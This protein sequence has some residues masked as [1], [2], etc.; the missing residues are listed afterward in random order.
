MTSTGPS[1]L[2]I[3]LLVL[4][5]NAIVFLSALGMVLWLRKKTQEAVVQ[6]GE[7]VQQFA[8]QITRLREFLHLYADLSWE[9]FATPVQ[10]LSKEAEQ[11]EAQVRDLQDANQALQ[12]NMEDTGGNQLQNIINAPYHWLMHWRQ[13]RDLR[14]QSA[15]INSR[16]TAAEN[17]TE[18]I[19]GLPWQVAMESRKVANQVEEITQLVETLQQNGVGGKMMQAILSQIP[20]IQQALRGVPPVF[21]SSEQSE[22]LTSADHGETG[23]VYKSIRRVQPNI[24]RWLPQLHGWKELYDNS[25]QE[26]AALQQTITTLRQSF[27]QP[28]AGLL[29]T[30]IKE[31]LDFV[32]ENTT[33]LGERLSQPEAEQLKALLREIIRL[34]RLAEDAGQRFETASKRVTELAQARATLK[35]SLDQLSSQLDALE[36][37]ETHPLVWNES[38]P[39]LLSL[40]QRLQALG[41]AEQQRTPEEIDAAIQEVAQIQGRQKELAEHDPKMAAQYETLVSL[42][43]SPEIQ[44]GIA[45]SRKTGEMIR[46]AEVYDPKSWQKPDA[47]Q[48]LQADLDALSALQE[49][50]VPEDP[51]AVIKESEL[52]ERLKETQQLAE[53]HKQLRPRAEAI[54]TRLNQ[55][56]ALE[57]EAAGKLKEANM[58]LET[59]AI[60]VDSNELLQTAAPEIKNLKNELQSLGNLLND[61]KQGT[62]EKK[63]QRVAS[64]SSTLMQT[65][66]G[67]LARLND[68]ISALGK[69]INE[70]LTEL[71][72]IAILEDPPFQD[73]RNLL[74]REDSRPGISFAGRSLERRSASKNYATAQELSAEIK[75]KNDLWQTFIAALEALDEKSETV[76]VAYREAIAARTSAQEQV[77]KVDEHLPQRRN[78]PPVNQ[79]PLEESQRL[80]AVDA[81]WDVMKQQHVRSDWAILEMGRLTQ[82]YRQVEEYARQL[83]ERVT[84][85]QERITDQEEQVKAVMER[86]QLM[87]QSAP[88]NA[89]MIQAIDQLVKN[90]A[91]QLSYIRTQYLRGTLNYNDVSHSLQLLYDEIYHAQV[92]LDDQHETGLNNNHNRPQP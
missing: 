44:E 21:L 60:L 79:A 82:Q 55:I 37:K 4:L 26:F 11:I 13:A 15:V 63:Q 9:P 48:T 1:A 8:E 83:I 66:S 27:A 32:V 17:E 65:M 36:K 50:L 34:R 40:Y 6:I 12:A 5:A 10:D 7:Q 42:L 19:H 72:A 59:V 86:W 23:Q 89:L 3:V 87:A 69:Q 84:Q 28:P 22:L 77:R 71:K 67:W 78:W 30:P 41:P 76:L 49:R 20:V 46:Q 88:D 29:I 81:K 18:R 14:Q 43:A 75:R 58:A 38:A 45:W 92:P 64:F 2:V 53:M 68:E 73:A 54:R 57:K 51:F 91:A 74:S 61:Q 62:I 16:L 80:K 70:Q 35:S 31:R 24:E 90:G 85:D 33:S 39:V 56:E 52:V 25:R 47:L